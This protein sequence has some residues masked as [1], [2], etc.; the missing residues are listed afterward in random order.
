MLMMTAD[1]RRYFLGPE[2]DY[3]DKEEL[4][5]EEELALPLLQVVPATP[6]MEIQE[7]S[8]VTKLQECVNC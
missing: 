6:A 2:Y 4:I 3:N 7:P 5:M 1:E 8:F